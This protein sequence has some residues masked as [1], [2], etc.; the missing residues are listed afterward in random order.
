M[1]LFKIVLFSLFL[2]NQMHA[3]E[4]AKQWVMGFGFNAVDDDGKPM[5]DIINLT[6][7]WNALP[8]PSMIT[9]ENYIKEGISL[10]FS[11]S[12]NSFRKGS[13][14]DGVILPQSRFFMALD[15][16]GKYHFNSLY[17]KL[18]WFDPYIALGLG[19]TTRAKATVPTGNVGFGGTFWLGSKVGINLQSSAK[20]S[21]MSSSSNYLQH[22]IGVKIKY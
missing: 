19:I 13:S 21:L 5:K 1:K 20:F 15:F 9:F 16:G 2:V 3:Q 7:G 11:Q 14:V 10:E 12:I 8:F 17:K 4:S 18:Y 22:S 6:N